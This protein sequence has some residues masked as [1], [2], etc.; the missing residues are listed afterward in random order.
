MNDPRHGTAAEP[1]RDLKAAVTAI[2]TRSPGAVSAFFHCACTVG[3]GLI[4][5][6][7]A[8][9]L[10]GCPLRGALTLKP[11]TS[12]EEAAGRQRQ[13][14]RRCRLQHTCRVLFFFYR[15][16]FVLLFF[17]FVTSDEQMEG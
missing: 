1:L 3:T 12:A 16:L 5:L 6:G 2:T 17:V 7:L 10:Y 15:F 11:R 14:P 9:G 4:R 8:R 13:V